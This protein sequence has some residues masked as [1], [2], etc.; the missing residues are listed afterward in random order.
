MCPSNF[1]GLGIQVV[2]DGNSVKV[3]KVI[4]ETPAQKGGVKVNDIITHLDD[5]SVD[6]LTLDQV[7][8][9]MRGRPNTEIKVRVAR[10]G[11]QIPIELSVT[12][13][14]VQRPSVQTPSTQW[15]SVQSQVQQ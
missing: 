9:K 13:G 15:P 14:V 1:V 6:G 7:T 3:V 8:E 5:E 2:K 10:E 12:R 4:D 11:Q